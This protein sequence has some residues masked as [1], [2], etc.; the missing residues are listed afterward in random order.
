MMQFQLPPELLGDLF[1]QARQGVV[2]LRPDGRIVGW[3]R[4]AER[5]FGWT[6]EEVV[7]HRRW[8]TVVRKGLTPLQLADCAM[9]MTGERLWSE[10]LPLAHRDGTRFYADVRRWSVSELAS[11]RQLAL[12]TFHDVTDYRRHIE[13][14]DRLNAAARAIHRER[15]PRVFEMVAE[16]ARQ[17]VRADFGCLALSRQVIPD[18]VGGLFVAGRGPGSRRRLITVVGLVEERILG[19]KPVW[20]DDVRAEFAT[21]DDVPRVG[22]LIA[23]SL[24]VG[25]EQLGVLVAGSRPG[26]VLFEERD[27]ALLA[28]LAEH[29]VTAVQYA[30]Q[31][32]PLATRLSTPPLDSRRI[33]RSKG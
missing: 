24:Q 26:A 10:Q 28:Q 25:V 12:L 2:V 29:A 16:T 19:A 4:A 9:L 22:P 23:A 11:T 32:R 14:L 3:N 27:M 8:P 20:I 6:A 5:L 17:L 7:G 1:W 31:R 15:G 21:S 30:R 18:E 13:D 33:K